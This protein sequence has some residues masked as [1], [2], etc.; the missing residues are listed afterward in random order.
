[1]NAVSNPRVQYLIRPENDDL[2]R[3]REIAA[4]NK[5]AGKT[6]LQDVNKLVCEAIKDYLAK[7][8]K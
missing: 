1:M 8:D 5:L 3:L 7:Q 2:N 6:E 4:Q